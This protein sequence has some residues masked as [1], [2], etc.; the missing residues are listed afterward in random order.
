MQ[1]VQQLNKYVEDCIT[2]EFHSLSE[3]SVQL[4]C[5]SLKILFNLLLSDEKP[6]ADWPCDPAQDKE[7]QRNLVNLV[8]KILTLESVKLLKQREE[9][10]W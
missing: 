5:E 10:K 9:L 7:I 1:G 4:C 3:N 2:E 8:R 6:S